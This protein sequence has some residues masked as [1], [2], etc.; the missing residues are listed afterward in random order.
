[1]TLFIF[2]F[3][4]PM[5]LFTCVLCAA[6][7]AVYICFARPMTLNI[8]ICSLCGRSCCLYLF[9]ARPMT[10]FIFVLCAADDTVYICSLRDR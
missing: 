7:D 1:M 4:R 9:F 6:G 5:T 8:Y 3:V 2:V 10:L